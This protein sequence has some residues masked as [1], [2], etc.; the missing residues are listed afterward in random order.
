MPKS[1]FKKKNPVMNKQVRSV[2][3][4][5]EKALAVDTIGTVAGEINQITVKPLGIESQSNG[6]GSYVEWSCPKII[7]YGYEPNEN[8]D[9]FASIVGKPLNA[10]RKLSDLH[11]FTSIAEMHIENIENATFD[12]IDEIEDILKSGV[13]I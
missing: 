10:V 1:Q 7:T 12:E 11:G 2:A 9:N 13:I 8:P 4:E 5:K 6:Y 3:N